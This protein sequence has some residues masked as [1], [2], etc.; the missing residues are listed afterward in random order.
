MITLKLC[1]IFLLIIFLIRFRTPLWGAVTAATILAAIL[2]KM[3]PLL[4]LNEVKNTIFGIDCIKLLLIT[5]GLILLQQ[6]MEAQNMLSAAEK[7]LC[8]LAP[9]PKVGSVISPIITG[10][11]PSPAAVLI[12]GSMFKK[13]Y[14]KVLPADIMA[15]I[16]T[17]FRHIPEALLPVYTNII[18][19]CA[20]T[21]TPEWKFLL[22]M[23]PYTV[24]NSLVP[25]FLYLKKADMP[26]TSEYHDLPRRTLFFHA[27]KALWP[28]FLIIILIL[29]LHIETVG[30]VFLTLLLFL[31]I[32]RFPFQKLCHFL[33]SSL[34]WNML[35]MVI[36]ILTFTNILS[37][38][39]AP[40]TLLDLCLGAKIPL[41]LIYGAI[42]FGG[43]I[44][45]NFTAMIPTVFPLAV[46]T[47]GSPVAMTIYLASLGHLANQLCPTHICISLCAEQ[48]KVSINNIFRHTLPVSIIMLMATTLLYLCMAVIF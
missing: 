43:S 41:F 37:L 16:T 27:F 35:L 9:N 34:N 32:N 14:E 40:D 19:I 18:L 48:F 17:Y 38:T 1:L 30:A 33:K 22:L 11:L 39:K 36:T 13:R 4:F 28:I 23:L 29:C 5:Y 10:L 21:G 15:F 44:S 46:S 25:Y 31:L 2:F 7:N 8:A 20:V 47:V 24:L 26:E 6:L 45:S 3:E 42:V 12:A